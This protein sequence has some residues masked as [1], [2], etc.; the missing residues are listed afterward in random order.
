MG[1]EMGGSMPGQRD[2]REESRNILRAGSSER[3]AALE[4]ARIYVSSSA[5]TAALEALDRV[6]RTGW[7]EEASLLRAE[8]LLGLGRLAE[9]ADLLG[10]P[11]LPAPVPSPRHRG[12]ATTAQAP[13]G[14]SGPGLKVRRSFHRKRVRLSMVERTGLWRF[15]LQLRVLH[16]SGRYA[17]VLGLGRAYFGRGGVPATSITARV[18]TVVA[19]SMLSTQRPAEARE[20]LEEV[21]ELYKQLQSKEGV[22]DTLLGIAN[23]H[24]L[25]CHWDEADALYQ[26]CRFRYEELG[27]TDKALAATI[28]LGVLR[29]KRGEFTSGRALL[30]QALVRATQI[31]DTRR[32][33]SIHLGLAMAEIRCG[34]H[35]EAR[36]QLVSA[37]YL[38]RRNQDR[39]SAVLALEFLGELQ[40]GQDPA[41]ARATLN[42]ALRKAERLSPTG[43][44]VFEV[45]RRLAELELGLGHI[46]AAESLAR[47]AA[48]GAQRFGDTYEIAVIDRVRAEIDEAQGNLAQALERA[49]EVA[50]ALDRLGETFERARV[51]ILRLRLAHCLGRISIESVRGRVNYLLRSVE[52]YPNSSLLREAKKLAGSISD[53]LPYMDA[54]VVERDLAPA[55]RPEL[56]DEDERTVRSLGLVSQDPAFRRMLM[57][58]RRVA[59][60]NVPVLILGEPGTGREKL[61]RLVHAWS[62]RP[63]IYVPFHCLDLPTAL[64]ESDLFG[65]YHD[66]GRSTG[67]LGA[68]HRG[69]LFLDDIGELPVGAQRKLYAWLR[70]GESMPEPLSVSPSSSRAD[71]H[72]SA[73][74]D[75]RIAPFDVRLVSAATV[76]TNR[77]GFS[78]GKFLGVT[79]EL[80][81]FLSR[82]VLELP[83][84]RE[85]MQDVPLQVSLLLD[86]ARQRHGNPIPDLPAEVMEEFRAR[87]WPGN[88][89]ELRQAVELHVIQNRGH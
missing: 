53:H 4:L 58:A 6:P 51:E 63:G 50:D 65:E 60:L 54:E 85:R 28:N 47:Q 55:T 45:R 1:Q 38:A 82:V 75:S 76:T 25:D 80:F 32:A 15:L 56:T 84:L 11:S 34:S 13:D 61:A 88:L 30:Q 9:A 69:T 16:R 2:S 66:G 18:A 46:G 59:A 21:L 20:L 41:R 49:E 8:A 86:Q 89:S 83:P 29:V 31:G 12:T 78:S 27:H 43:D 52:R 70:A 19:Q 33:P 57:L 23:T 10:A 42:L 36:R 40:L 79:D 67:L 71:W 74:L 37:L 26:E 48:V 17:Q 39:R 87:S 3:R 81:R 73:Y 72:D 5:Y 64:V 44:I 77:S 22:A 35:G 62:G 68:S 14:D 24:L 7:D